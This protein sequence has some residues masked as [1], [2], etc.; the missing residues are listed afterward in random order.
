MVRCHGA[1]RNGGPRCPEYVHT[2]DEFYHQQQQVEG[3]QSTPT[4]PPPP[5]SNVTYPELDDSCFKMQWSTS[6][7]TNNYG[8]CINMTAD[9]QFRYITSNA[10]PDFY[11]S[12][13]CP[14]G[15]GYGY[16]TQY[17]IDHDQCFFTT[18]TCGQ[19]NGPGS[20]QLGDVWVPQRNSYKIPL[21]GNPTRPDVPWD[22]YDARRVGG[23][24]TVG[25]ATGVAINGISIQGPNDAGDLSI[26]AAGFQLTCGGHVTPPLGNTNTSKPGPA[27]PPMYHF[28]KAPDCLEP[29]RN[30]SIEVS[31]DGRPF[32]HGKL[33]GWAVDGFSIYSYQDINGSVPIVDECGGH[34]G[35]IDSTGTVAYHYHSRA[36]VPYHLACQ[37][38]S[39]SKCAKTQGSTNYCHPGCGADVCV[40]PGTDPVKLHEYLDVFD[41]HW[42]AKYT[43]NDYEPKTKKGFVEVVYNYFTS[44]RDQESGAYFHYAI[45]GL[46]VLLMVICFATI[47]LKTK[48]TPSSGKR[49]CKL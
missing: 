13:Y 9:F 1:Y 29:F 45:Y 6:N 43:T 35:P 33:V 47:A 30:A 37:G 44:S 38:P 20:T 49:D 31:K 27:G 25:P 3:R 41:P 16:C 8:N 7:K 26:D 32:E 14:I 15:V 21:R 40:Q 24:K 22:M 39:L 23:E 42:L 48:Q 46:L 28:H 17:E 11:F 2:S 34:F 10:V 12:P 36:N 18:L 5:P 4:R 19:D